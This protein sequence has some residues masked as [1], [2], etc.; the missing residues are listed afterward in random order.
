MPPIRVCQLITELRPAGA[1]RCVYELSRRLDSSRFHVRVAALRGGQVADDLRAAG[2]E[3]AV[4]GVRGK[5][6]VGGL[7]RLAGTLRKWRIDLLHTHLFHAD[8]AG[9]L[10][11]GAA[12]VRRLVHTVHVAERRCRPWQF[13]WARLAAGR[14]DQLLAVSADVAAHHAARSGLPPRAYQVIPNGIDVAAFARDEESRKRLRAEWGAAPGQIVLAAVARLDRQKGLDVLLNAAG[15]L[16][17]AEPNF[18]IVIAGD[19][20]LRGRLEAL[21]GAL[22]LGARTRFL[23][24]VRDARAVLSAAD[25]FAMPSRWEGFGL[26]AVEAMAAGLPVIASRAEGLREVVQDG[27]TG[28]L[29]DVEDAAGFAKNIHICLHDAA[30]RGR[31]GLAG[32]RRAEAFFDISA[33]VR[34]HERLYERIVE[35]KRRNSLKNSDV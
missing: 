17:P 16:A 27:Q 33:M 14:C 6:D 5:W 13:A 12:G 2:V 23:G 29:A 24:F 3:T 18:R 4:V 31:L 20:P 9:R 11:A 19:G 26:A 25:V 7:A 30:L 10:V 28:L 21:A 32:K 34:S 22:R 8:L 35:T 15:M 1:E